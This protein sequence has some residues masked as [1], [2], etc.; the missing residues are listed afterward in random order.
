MPP[1]DAVTPTD[2]EAWGLLRRLDDPDHVETPP[3]F[4]RPAAVARFRALEEGLEAAFGGKVEADTWEHVQDASH[5]GR[6]VVP[7]QLTASGER[8]V[9]TVS[10]FAPL[11]SVSL[12][13]PGVHD[14]AEFDALL[15]ESDG[16][17]LVRALRT[18]DHFVVPEELMWKTYDGNVEVF[19]DGTW[20]TRYFDYI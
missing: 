11:V 16:Q 17:R 19:G 5:F 3:G 14:R 18:I 15:E 20:W 6:L 13:N 1:L 12:G 2:D 7:H 10:N 8:I 9:V 4:D